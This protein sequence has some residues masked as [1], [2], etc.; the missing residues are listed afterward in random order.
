ML[1]LFLILSFE[2]DCHVVQIG[3][4]LCVMD[5]LYAPTSQMLELQVWVTMPSLSGDKLLYVRQTLN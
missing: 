2:T 5:D 1:L 4:E 3:L